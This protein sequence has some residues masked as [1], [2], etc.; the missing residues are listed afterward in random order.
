MLHASHWLPKMSHDGIFTVHKVCYYCKN[1]LVVHGYWS[2]SVHWTGKSMIKEIQNTIIIHQLPY[3]SIFKELAHADTCLLANIYQFIY[4]G[5][6]QMD[7]CVLS[8]L[9][10]R[11][12]SLLAS[13]LKLDGLWAFTERYLVANYS[14]THAVGVAFM[15]NT[16]LCI[17]EVQVYTLVS[18]YATSVPELIGNCF[19][20]SRQLQK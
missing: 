13:S 1:C 7:A 3:N 8:R 14:S 2:F 6:Y 17:F 9:A 5:Y 10:S 11:Q 18:Y 4:A 20:N 15:P 16:L 19:Y 12:V